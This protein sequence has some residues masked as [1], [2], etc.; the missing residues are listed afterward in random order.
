MALT[1]AQILK[2]ESQVLECARRFLENHDYKLVQVINETGIDPYFNYVFKH[3][4]DK[5]LVFVNVT[6]QLMAEEFIDAKIDR[7]EWERR[8]TAWLVREIKD[9]PDNDYT[10]Y[11]IRADIVCVNILSGSKALIR[12]H[13]NALYEDAN[14]GEDNE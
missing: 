5:E 3:E 9:N 1:P 8:M 6:Y 10:G 13:I 2:T 4:G 11:S 14:E 12:H 7:S